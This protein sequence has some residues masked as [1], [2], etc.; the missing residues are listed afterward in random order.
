M[1]NP[2]SHYCNRPP[3]FK[4]DDCI[5]AFK[6]RRVACRRLLM[7]YPVSQPDWIV[8]DWTKVTCKQCLQWWAKRVKYDHAN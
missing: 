3:V 1:S 5:G 4:P 8:S 7:V 6:A 2:V